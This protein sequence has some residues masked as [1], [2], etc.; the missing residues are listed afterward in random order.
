MEHNPAADSEAVSA[1]A[2]ASMGLFGI[3]VALVPLL[4]L[5]FSMKVWLP[6]GV[7]G[8]AVAVAAGVFCVRV[9][10]RCWRVKDRSGM[11]MAFAGALANA[12]AGVLCTAWLV[13]AQWYVNSACA[14]A[15]GC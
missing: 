1:A 15:T 12:G 4:A 11:L 6:A 3:T 9:L 14:T 5:G 7:L 2:H 10:V 13:F 8:A